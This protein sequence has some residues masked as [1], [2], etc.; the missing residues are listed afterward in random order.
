MKLTKR[1]KVDHVG[2]ANLNKQS[3]HLL[4]IYFDWFLNELQLLIRQGL[5]KK[6]YKEKGNIRVLK[7]KL[8]FADQINKNL[9][10]KERFYTSHQ[11]YE[12]D[13]LVHQILGQALSI[14]E[15][16]SNGNYLYSKCKKI[17][18]D[19]P[20]VQKIKATSVT[21][22]SIPNVRK[23]VP[24]Q[25]ALQIARLIILNYAPNIS[26]GNENLLALLFDMNSLWEEYILMRLKNAAHNEFEIH[27]QKSKIFWNRNTIRPD[28]VIR[29]GDETFIVDTKWKNINGNIPSTDDLR[30]MYVYNEYWKSHKAVLLYPSDKSEYPNFKQFEGIIEKK[31]NHQCG[32]GRIS[33]FN[34]HNFKLRVSIGNEILEW[35][36]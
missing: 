11:V 27:G 24:Y 8:E 14:V 31:E 23:L 28:I 18:L 29:K 2:E 4:D 21:F 34:S 36:N 5:I 32:L 16:M 9:I 26:S 7:G 15:Q 19:F 30:Q 3:I 33:I 6:Y 20:D 17:S 35:F 25:T 1:L 12:K 22:D 13:H 10:H